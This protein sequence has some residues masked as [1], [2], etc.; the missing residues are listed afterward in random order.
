M[1]DPIS[2]HFR[3]N[4]GEGLTA[5][6]RLL[7]ELG[8]RSFLRFWSHAN[9][10]RQP[11]K[12]L[13]DLLV[14][15]G[16]YV[17]F[18]SD[19]SV[20]FKFDRPEDVEWRAWYREAVSES[21]KQLN[22]AIR[23]M[24]KLRVPIYKDK[25]CTV[26][27][28]IPIPEPDKIRLYKIA[29]TSLSQDAEPTKEGTPY[30]SF[31]GALSEEQHLTDDAVPFLLGDVTSR[32]EF[33]HVFDLAG[34]GAVLSSLDTVTDFAN[35]LDSRKSF[36]RNKPHNSAANEWCMLTR[37]LFAFTD[38]GERLPLDSANPGFT[39]LG[40]SEWQSENT[41][42]ALSQRKSANQ[43]SYA[44]D[45]LVEYYASLL[46]SGRFAQSTLTSVEDGERAFRHMALE[47][48]LNRRTLSRKWIETCETSVPDQAANL[49]TADF[50]ARGSTT[51][52][53]FLTL[54]KPETQDYEEYRDT[55]RNLLM[56]VAQAAFSDVPTS[57]V[58]IGFASE[59][60]QVPDSQ[61]IVVIDIG[62]EPDLVKFWADVKSSSE[63]KKQVFTVKTRFEVDERDFS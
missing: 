19:K 52:Y 60:G 53:V 63:L 1:T 5:T 24:I 21:V 10:H 59:L 41:K 20:N 51:T 33:T 13:C 32:A 17:F 39:C 27:L 56:H 11:G 14:I 3:I 38:E 2:S 36:I 35:Y 29:L 6:E 54:A 31:S 16:E 48:R 18:F 62:R 23:R 43:E 15:C 55:R 25:E 40:N 49:R 8:E 57:N 58:V 28:G 30:L 46:E 45:G 26:P 42:A 7:K 37:Y 4:F 44:W 22:G 9:P 47:N 12:E 34:L 50:S 61:D